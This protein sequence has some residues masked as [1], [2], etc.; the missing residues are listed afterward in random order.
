M[1][2]ATHVSTL[3]LAIRT[4]PA[5]AQ[6]PVGGGDA[7]ARLHPPVFLRSR[8]QGGFGHVQDHRDDP[9]SGTAHSARHCPDREREICRIIQLG[10][11][12]KFNNYCPRSGYPPLDSATRCLNLRILAQVHSLTGLSVTSRSPCGPMT[13][14]SLSTSIAQ[15]H[16]NTRC[17]LSSPPLTP[18]TEKMRQSSG[19]PWTLSL[20]ATLSA[21][22]C[23]GSIRPRGKRSKISGST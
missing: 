5:A 4:T 20:A 18:Y 2:A 11:H 9:R 17:C 8:H 1:T 12:G 15:V 19:Q 16:P 3:T 14:S 6:T 7:A 21:S 22:S 10:Q 23:A 13:A